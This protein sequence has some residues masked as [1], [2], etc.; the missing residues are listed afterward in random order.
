MK[1]EGLGS[2]PGHDFKKR[3]VL[4]LNRHFS[5]VCLLSAMWQLLPGYSKNGGTYVVGLPRKVTKS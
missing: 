4:D 2:R 5:L 1:D 3:Y